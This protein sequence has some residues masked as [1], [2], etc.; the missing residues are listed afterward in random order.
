VKLAESPHVQSH[1][2][3]TGEELLRLPQVLDE[4]RSALLIVRTDQDNLAKVLVDP[5]FRQVPPPAEQAGAEPVPILI[6][7]R[8]TTFEAGTGSA[9]D[10]CAQ[11]R[12]VF[13]F[14]GFDYDLD[15]GQVVPEGQGGDL[16]FQTGGATKHRLEMVPPAE[17]LTLDQ[18]PE[19]LEDKADAPST[20]LGVKP[21]DYAGRYQL[22]ADGTLTGTLVLEVENREV[23]GQFRSEASGT[24]YP[25]TGSIASETNPGITWTI[26]YP[27]I[28]QEYKGRLFSKGK[29]AIAGSVVMDQ[30][31]GAFFA[32]REA[33]PLVISVAPLED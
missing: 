1:E 31:Q 30:R 29:S 9:S 6:L 27:Q 33:G 20:G 26:Q 12:S 11:G 10:R 21:D 13:L 2:Q 18:R 32:I 3:L 8:F 4:A 16:R 17:L 14:S 7:E 15:V 24:S 22:F 23:S 28:K 25:V 19:V 5:A